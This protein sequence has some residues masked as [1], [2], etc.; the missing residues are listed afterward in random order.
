V[1]IGWR[2]YKNI[3]ISSQEADLLFLVLW[4]R[5]S[6]CDPLEWR[7]VG[8]QLFLLFPPLFGAPSNCALGS[9][10]SRL[11]LDSTLNITPFRP[12]RKHSIDAV[13]CVVCLCLSY[14]H[15]C[16]LQKR[17]N[18]S[19]CRLGCDSYGLKEQCVWWDQ[20][21]TNPFKAAKGDKLAMQPFAKLL[22]IFVINSYRCYKF[23]ITDVWQCRV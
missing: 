23:A 11:P 17:L 3:I 7:T 12:H 8:R 6:D 1:K 10:P 14:S 20:D 13:Y 22:W 19:R 16:A 18:R 4:A 21:R 2:N 9:C 5:F 15:G